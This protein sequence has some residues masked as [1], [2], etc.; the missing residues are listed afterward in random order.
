MWGERRLTEASLT[1]AY[2]MCGLE[3]ARSTGHGFNAP[4]Y[5]LSTVLL[6][7]CLLIGIHGDAN[8]KGLGFPLD[9]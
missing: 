7:K 6:I 4:L 5:R 1:S 8:G 2:P 3:P 9:Y